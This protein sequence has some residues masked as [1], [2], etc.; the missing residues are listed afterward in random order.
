MIR[1]FELP[2]ID[3]K[4]LN[5]VHQRKGAEKKAGL[6]VTTESK[7]RCNYIKKEPLTLSACGS[8]KGDP[9]NGGASNSRFIPLFHRGCAGGL[10][11]DITLPLKGGVFVGAQNRVPVRAFLLLFIPDPHGA[12]ELEIQ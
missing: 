8:D 7:V 2:V 9:S 4:A 11:T 1:S 5:P 12:L 10:A 6:E 3:S